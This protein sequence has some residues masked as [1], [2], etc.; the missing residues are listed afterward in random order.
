MRGNEHYDAQRQTC[1]QNCST[2]K[3]QTNIVEKQK[4]GVVKR[5]GTKWYQPGRANQTTAQSLCM[6]HSPPT[7]SFESKSHNEVFR[8]RRYVD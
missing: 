6:C 8:T 1:D 2:E 4:H 3:G 5:C 7:Y